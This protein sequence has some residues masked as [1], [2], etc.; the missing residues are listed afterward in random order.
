MIN[1]ENY[2][3]LALQLAKQGCLTVSPNPMVGCIL[4]K[5]QQIIGQG[6]HQYAGGPHA[7]AHALAAA[8]SDAQGATAY[9]TL[10]PCCHS[11]KRT[12]PCT[13]ALI[14][15]GIKKV[16]VACLDPNPQV[17]GKGIQ[18]LQ[19]AGIT[20]EIGLQAEAATQLNQIFFHYIQKQRPFVIAKWAMSLDGKTITQ[21]GDSKAI[22]NK[23]S[24][25][26]AHQLRQQVDA[27]LIGAATASQDDPLLTARVETT[28]NIKPSKQ[29]LRIILSTKGD[30][31]N[32]LRLF[33][34]HP[35]AKTLIATTTDIPAKT[36][37]YFTKKNIE[38]LILPKN[39][40]GLVDLP[41]LLDNLGKRDITSLLIEGG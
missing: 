28:E 34:Q 23:T 15:A 31:P 29:P 10:E 16:Y 18:Q 38:V 25:N 40:R 9:I 4:L 33:D 14:Q 21:S 11:K 37:A 22:S 20:V 8:G 5:N 32:N 7:E 13:T 19:E 35:T 30:L 12:P 41:S 2:M 39:Q 3:S 24:Q 26:I 17:A 27:I 36:I 1:H 6:Y